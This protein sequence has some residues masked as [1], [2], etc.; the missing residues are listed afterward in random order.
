[1]AQPGGPLGSPATFSKN[2]RSES[3]AKTSAPIGKPASQTIKNDL[4][5]QIINRGKKERQG[6]LTLPF[7]PTARTMVCL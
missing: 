3:E 6:H 2:Q 7:P 5:S 1:M 4:Q